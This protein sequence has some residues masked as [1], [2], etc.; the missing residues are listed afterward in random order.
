MTRRSVGN[1]I[2]KAT[3]IAFLFGRRG[4]SQTSARAATT[5]GTD[6]A[7]SAMPPIPSIYLEEDGDY[8]CEYYHSGVADKLANRG[9]F[10]D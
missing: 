3:G 6:A 2:A 7:G 9:C 1:F 10:N 4:G 8:H 5:F